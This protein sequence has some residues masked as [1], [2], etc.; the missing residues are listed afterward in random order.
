MVFSSLSLS[1]LSLTNLLDLTVFLH[2]CSTTDSF[3][4]IA[5]RDAIAEFSAVIAFPIQSSYRTECLPFAN[6]LYDASHPFRI[7]FQRQLPSPSKTPCQPSAKLSRP[8]TVPTGPPPQETSSKQ[9]VEGVCG[10]TAG[11]VRL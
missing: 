1:P 10:P 2:F 7:P 3:N 9:T 5:P 6:Q 8:S 11:D 4:R